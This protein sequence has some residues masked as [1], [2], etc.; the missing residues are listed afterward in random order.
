MVKRCPADTQRIGY[1]TDDGFHFFCV[2]PTQ[3]E[4]KR[5]LARKRYVRRRACRKFN[6][7]TKKCSEYQKIC[8]RR[9]GYGKKKVTKRKTILSTKGKP[10]MT[11]AQRKVYLGKLS[12]AMK[13]AHR[14]MKQ[15]G[16]DRSTAVKAGRKKAGL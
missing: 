13:E 8:A 14:L 4:A 1:C 11:G 7:D 15:P 3:A 10:V 9:K 2:D 6:P 5:N 16:M 12:K